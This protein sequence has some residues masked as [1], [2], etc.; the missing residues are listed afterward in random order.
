[1]YC[2]QYTSGTSSARGG[3]GRGSSNTPLEA[4]A[5]APGQMHTRTK[6]HVPS[7]YHV[8][9]HVCMDGTMLWYHG[10]H[11]GTTVWMVVR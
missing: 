11:G 10:M 8:H 9:M 2:I 3:R 5:Y 4:A 7:R 6:R 1:M